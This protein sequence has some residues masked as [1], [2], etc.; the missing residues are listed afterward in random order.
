[1]NGVVA[2]ANAAAITLFSQ[3]HADNTVG[4]LR[5]RMVVDS[6]YL[7]SEALRDYLSASP[8]NYAVLSDYAAMEAFKGDPQVIYRSIEILAERSKSGDSR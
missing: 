8:E 6:N 5:M 1:L 3:C 2:L 7:Q 4:G